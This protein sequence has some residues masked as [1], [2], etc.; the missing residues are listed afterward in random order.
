MKLGLSMR[1][2]GYHLAAWRHPDFDPASITRFEAYR[3]IARKAEEAKLDMIFF[4]DGL[5]VR[6]EAKPEGSLSHD[7]R[8]AD[9]EPLTLLSAIAATT[10]HI[11]LVA[12]SSTTYNEP[13]HI[14]RRYAS[15]DMISHG[16]AGWNVVTSWSE[17]EALNFNR[18]ENLPKDER[19][20]RAQEFVEVVCGLWN[21]FKADAFTHDKKTGQFYDPTKMHVLDHKGKHFQVRGPLTSGVTPQGRPLIVQAGASDKG[22]DIAAQYADVVYS[23]AQNVDEARAFYSDIKARA[24]QQGRKNNAP[25]IMPALAFYV[26]ETREAAQAKFDA[27]QALID[28]L[29]G[30]AQL[31]SFAGDLSGY[32]LDKPIP[33]DHFT[34]KISIGSGLLKQA[35]ETG[36]TIRQL[37]EQVAAGFTVRYVIGSAE[38]IV[39]DMQHWMETGAADGF[40]LCP[41]ILPN[42]LDDFIEFI[43]PELRRRGLFRTEY[44]GKTLH[45]NLGLT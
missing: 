14:A 38:E 5:A 15:L 19:Y 32:D 3:D 35:R 11:G 31:Y 29:A 17:Q 42:S 1:Y 6:N 23:V 10:S 2:L 34:D 22:R 13:Y 4:A 43:L 39:D 44:E 25:L 36:M 8:N 30:L 28:P 16:R 41:P 37:Y 33:E 9:L 24:A 12:T 45:E 40:N 20:D 7:M 27:L 26:G 18:T 21:S